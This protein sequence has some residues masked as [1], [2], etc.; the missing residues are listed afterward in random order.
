MQEL[1]LLMG[2]KNL[3]SHIRKTLLRVRYG[4]REELLPLIRLKGIGRVRAR[5]LY[6]ANIRSLE[7][8]RKVPLEALSRVTGPNIAKDIKEQLNEIGDDQKILE[9]FD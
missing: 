2:K 3:L 4:I 8:L 7:D 1:A 6:N 9:S 5:M